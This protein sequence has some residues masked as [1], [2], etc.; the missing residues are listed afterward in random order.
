MQV[1]Y[2]ALLVSLLWHAIFGFSFVWPIE[3]NS[4]WDIQQWLSWWK[5]WFVGDVRG[6]FQTFEV[7]LDDEEV[8]SN[9]FCLLCQNQTPLAVGIITPATDATINSNC[10]AV[11]VVVLIAKLLCM[12]AVCGDKLTFHVYFQKIYNVHFAKNGVAGLNSLAETCMSKYCWLLCVYNSFDIEFL[13]EEKFRY[14][15]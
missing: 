1:L 11:S 12:L 10:R 8:Y 2:A 15:H 9:E 7:C 14:R 3:R 13:P 5:S 6:Y 4:T